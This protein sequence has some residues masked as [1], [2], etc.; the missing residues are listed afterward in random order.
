MSSSSKDSS[1]QVET[2]VQN[3]LETS[4]NSELQDQV[5][6]PYEPDYNS[7][8]KQAAAS[9]SA[10][11]TQD[12]TLFNN[13]DERTLENKDGNKSDDANFDQVSGI[14]SGSLEIPI[15]NSA[16]SNIRLTPSD[17]YNNIPVSDTNNEEIS[18]NIYGAPILESTSS[19]F[20][21]KDS[22]STTQPS[23]SGGNGSTSQSP[24]SLDVEQNKF[25]SIS[26]EPVEQETENSSTKDLQVYDFQTASEHLPEQSL[27]NTT[28][29]DP[30]KT[31]SSVN[32]EE[33][34]YGKSHEK[35]DLPY[36]TTDFIPYS[37]DLSTSPEAHRTSIYSY[38]A[39][40]PNY[41]NEHNELHEHH[42]P[43][44]PSSPESAYSPENLQLNHEAQNVEYL[45]NNAAE[46]SLQMNLEDEQR[47][48]QFLKD[49]ESIMSNWYPGQFPSASRLFLGHLNTK[50]LSKRNLWKVFK[51]YGPLAQIVLKANYGFVQFFTNEDCARALNAEQG[52][53]VRGQKL[54]L[55]I[56]KIQK[57]YQNQIE[58][59]KKGS[60]VAKSNQYSEMIGNLPYPTSSR[61]RTRSPLMSKG[62]SYD[63]KGSISMSKNFSPD[64][65]ILVT[66]DCPKEFVWGVEKVFQ[67]RRLNIH[68][69]CL[70]RDSNLQV[71]IKSCIINSVK[72]IILINA[73]LAHLG[74]VSV[75]VFKDGSSD[76]EVRCDEYAAVDVMVAASIVH[77]AKTSLMH[78]AASS[79]PSYNGERIVPDV[80]SPCVSTNPNLPALVGSLDSVNLHHL[81]GFIQ[82]T[83]STTSYIPT[84]VSFNPND[85]GGSFGTITS[86]S[87]F[88]VNE[89]PE[90][91]ARDNYEALHSQESRQ[92]S[93]VAGNKQLQKI[94]EQLA[95]LK[96]P[97]F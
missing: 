13:V 97:D 30:S 45:G 43:Q 11:Q 48:Q 20:Q 21:S 27:Q 19:D 93:S 84:R 12:D 47:F 60:H 29:Y 37:K 73:G 88:V 52:N 57:K 9:I 51:I 74:K 64:C 75:Q 41:Y 86:Q 35:L 36:R 24:P 25:F 81:L 58:N 5:S 53:F 69:T 50:S 54:H 23:V 77:H 6:S 40:L 65:E 18:K 44:T 59:M 34:E 22:L 83:Y 70:Y 71:I 94:L 49:E 33:I 4:T 96:Q 61:K 89:R 1:F 68:T 14:P 32:F 28:Y 39:N 55:E 80:P 66:E 87:Q 3:I 95:E 38:S 10:L 63:R 46:K 7:P 78:S 15:L 91:Y 8:V 82:N 16:T 76:S 56:S 90:N 17:T 85:T 26:N 31:Y 62:K 92:R 2:P 79:T 72:S 67:E 42:N